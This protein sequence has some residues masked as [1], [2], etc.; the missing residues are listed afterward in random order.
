MFRRVAR[1]LRLLALGL[2]IMLIAWIP[3]SWLYA[4]GVSNSR[5][6]LYLGNGALEMVFDRPFP[7]PGLSFGVSGYSSATRRYSRGLWATYEPNP[8]WGT[9]VSI[10]LWLL[11]LLCLAWPVTSF[12]R[13]R[14]RRG[15]GFEVEAKAPS[16]STEGALK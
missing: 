10:P 7:E 2:G 8:T 14:R 5:V 11:A 1:A 6:A 15:R 3:F 12:I 13:A 4:P 9:T 16:D